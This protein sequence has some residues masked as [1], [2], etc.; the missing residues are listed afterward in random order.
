MKEIDR[1][2]HSR[3]IKHIVDACVQSARMKGLSDASG[4][5]RGT[6]FLAQEPIS[7]DELVEETGYSKS[8]V[9]ANMSFLESMGMVRRVVTPGDK[10]YRYLPITDTDSM[11]ATMLAHIR[12]E[13]QLLLG[14]LDMTER[15]LK[16]MEDQ[17][18]PD[19][20][21]RMMK[22]IEEIRH[23]YRQNDRLISL[24]N[25]KTMDELIE[26]LEKSN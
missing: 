25:N 3:L 2:V 26:L 17:V 9:S 14:A 7:M 21:E 18:S 10:R 1:Q 23:F 19:I 22:G 12:K 15:D 5:L 4:V 20:S 16:A 11:R 24:L 8:T 13:I 6:L